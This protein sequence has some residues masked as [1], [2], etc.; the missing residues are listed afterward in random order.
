MH[1]HDGSGV[2]YNIGRIREVPTGFINTFK[3]FIVI[4]IISIKVYLLL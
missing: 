3:K 2:H 4:F 1:E